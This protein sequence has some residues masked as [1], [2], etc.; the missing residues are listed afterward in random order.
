M[1]PTVL[2]SEQGRHAPQDDD[3]K[4]DGDCAE[5]Q[6]R[7][8]YAPP[9]LFEYSPFFSRPGLQ[10]VVCGGIFRRCRR[11]HPSLQESGGCH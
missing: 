7:Q 9:K 4:K 10:G 6:S 3:D 8:G 5:R 11:R 1:S 2:A